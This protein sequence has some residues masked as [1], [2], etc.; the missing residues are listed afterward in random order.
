MSYQIMLTILFVVGI[1]FTFLHFQISVEKHVLSNNAHNFIC[2]W[3][4][5][6]SVLRS[7]FVCCMI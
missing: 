6:Y 4:S 1:A 3:N 5:F 7:L 2:C